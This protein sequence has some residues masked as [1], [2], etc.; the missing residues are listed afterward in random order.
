MH[1]RSNHSAVRMF[2]SRETAAHNA[3]YNST[4]STE[5][6]SAAH[7]AGYLREEIEAR[8]RSWDILAQVI[9]GEQIFY[10]AYGYV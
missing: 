5:D 9:V 4:I 10:R 7:S 8:P 3:P 1:R 2:L 6:R